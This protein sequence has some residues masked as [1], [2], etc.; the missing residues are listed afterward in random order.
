MYDTYGKVIGVTGHTG[1]RPLVLADHVLHQPAGG[2]PYAWRFG[3]GLPRLKTLDADG[4]V[5]RLDSGPA[6]HLQLAYTPKLDT[7]SNIAD[8]VY[9][10]SQ[11]SSFGYDRNDRLRTVVRSGA[12]QSF[13]LDSVANR[14]LQTINGTVYD[15]DVAPG[16]NRLL[17]VNGGGLH[18]SFAHDLAGNITQSSVAGSSVGYDYDGFNR[19]ERVRLNGTVVGTY[20]Y[21]PNGQ[22][23]WKQTPAGTTVFV[24][25]PNAELLYESGPA[26]TTAYVWLGA[27]LLGIM[28]G[29]VFYASHNDHLGRP[30]VMTNEAAQVVWRAS[31]QAFT[32]TVLSS[33]I[34]DMNLGFPGQFFDAESGLWSNWHRCF[35]SATGRYTQ[36]DPIGLAGGINTYAYVGGNPISFVDPYGLFC[37][38]A[39]AREAVIGA[40]SGGV[41][42]LVTG[43]L[44]G[45]VG[46]AVGGTVAGV[47]VGGVMGAV[48]GGATA[49]A[50]GGA[51][52]VGGIIE[53]HVGGGSPVGAA[54][55]GAA[56][57][58]L[59]GAVGGRDAAQRAAAQTAGSGVAGALAGAIARTGSAAGVAAGFN[60]GGWAGLAG[61]A[62]GAVVDGL[63]RGA[64]PLC[65]KE[66]K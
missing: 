48:G 41:N 52:A 2:A 42:G 7:V 59:S 37:M 24:H 5:T 29:G 63:L 56:G 45:G 8:M 61:G 30:E 36:S 3:N 58:A 62:A 46:G 53:A 27:E 38:D 44:M 14:D 10:A 43:G 16:S 60:K 32:R 54:V 19:L 20:G 22:R 66:C 33:S 25:G 40:A 50:S 9:G 17:G 23:L 55:A 15:F 28:R 57:G 21:A 39:T 4:R 64:I 47:L 12:N 65:K 13:E 26:G 31:N 6:Q 35:D 11:S 34:G 1:T 18:R 49:L 51:G